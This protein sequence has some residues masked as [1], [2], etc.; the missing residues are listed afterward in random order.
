MLRQST[1]FQQDA[2]APAAPRLD[3]AATV[4]IHD[5]TT[6]RGGDAPRFELL[7]QRGE[8]LAQRRVGIALRMASHIAA[9]RLDAVNVASAATP[10]A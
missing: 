8:G 7:F 10:T 5:V 2:V 3:L 6:V 4:R 9:V 1:V